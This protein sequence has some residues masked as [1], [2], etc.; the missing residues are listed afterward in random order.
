MIMQIVGSF[1]DVESIE[2]RNQKTKN[3]DTSESK[4]SEIAEI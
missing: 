3:V 1:S 2:S 4:G